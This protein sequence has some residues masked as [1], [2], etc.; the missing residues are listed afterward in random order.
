MNPN[1]NLDELLNSF[2][3]GEL[4]DRQKTEVQRMAA[5]DPEVSRRLR[6]L[7]NC[8]TLFRSLPAAPAPADLF[9]QVRQ[10]LERRSLLEEQPGFTRW[11]LGAWHLVGRKLISAA[12]VIA[13][14]GVLGVV[15]YQILSPV[16]G[17]GTQVAIDL[18]QP[19][20]GPGLAP[21]P[22]VPA[23]GA[24]FSGR[25]ELQ[26]A[27]LVQADASIRR[28]IEDNG[29]ATSVQFDTAGDRRVYRLVTTREGVNRLMAS[30]SG[31][32]PNFERAAL[33]VDRLGDPARPVMVPAVN[34]DQI[35]SILARN[36]TEASIQA[37]E[38]YALTNGIAQ[39]IPG[40]EIL[41]TIQ[42]EAGGTLSL[43]ATPRPIEASNDKT[44]RTTL[45]P[46]Q[47]KP[48]ASLTI[49]LL[50]TSR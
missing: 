3:D 39:D 2:V 42:D 27:A 20:G 5:R 49:V 38:G 1:P 46:P 43:G 24:M 17:P 44:T 23:G 32:W 33:L 8:H 25:L 30:L 13:L 28:V 18:G 15:V 34:P 26:T 48:E 36:S 10:S 12:A 31:M 22:S 7:Q 47:G 6:Q 35:V 19:G 41:K 11:S 14:L 21:V 9:E 29:L 4:S 40:H 16:A 37:A 50:G 45:A